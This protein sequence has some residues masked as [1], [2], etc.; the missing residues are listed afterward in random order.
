MSFVAN[1]SNGGKA[2]PSAAV[3]GEGT[4]L[5]LVGASSFP[6]GTLCCDGLRFLG[7]AGPSAVSPF[8]ATV[9]GQQLV[10]PSGQYRCR[11]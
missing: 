4:L 3:T 10:S 2:T 11:K 5:F 9:Y 1:K 8:R 6:K 7:F